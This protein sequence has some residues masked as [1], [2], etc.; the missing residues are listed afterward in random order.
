[1]NGR[2]TYEQIISL[3]PGQK[4]IIASGLSETNEVKKTQR[5]GAGR[6]FKK[7]YTINQ[8]GYAVKKELET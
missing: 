5:L 8:L 6:F 3:Y 2:K 1:M 4:A 7:P